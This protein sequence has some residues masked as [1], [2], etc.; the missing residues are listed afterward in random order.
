MMQLSRESGA[1]RSPLSLPKRKG[2]PCM[3]SIFETLRAERE[4]R[5]YIMGV[6][7]ITGL[8]EVL[9]W[10]GMFTLFIPTD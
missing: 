4:C 6:E 5:W 8:T 1:A 2:N 3:A 7:S 10:S 9:S